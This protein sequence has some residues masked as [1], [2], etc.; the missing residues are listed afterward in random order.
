MDA[1]G[2]GDGVQAPGL[3]FW[4]GVGY[5]GWHGGPSPTVREAEGRGWGRRRRGEER[6]GDPEALPRARLL[7]PELLSSLSRRHQEK[8]ATHRSGSPTQKI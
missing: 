8:S 6:G 4:L 1:K 2:L 7:L 3:Y 5:R